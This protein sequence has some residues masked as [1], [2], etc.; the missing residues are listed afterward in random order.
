[1]KGLLATVAAAAAALALAA[2]GLSDVG[3][4]ADAYAKDAYAKDVGRPGDAYA[5][6]AFAKDAFAKDAFRAHL[7]GSTSSSLHRLGLPWD[8]ARLGY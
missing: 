4:P 3:R 2:P 7:A 5:K 6:D 8:A 1:M